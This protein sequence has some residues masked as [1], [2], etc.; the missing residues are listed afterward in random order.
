MK[1]M[2]LSDG[3]LLKKEVSASRPPAEAPM[4]TIGKASDEEGIL[5]FSFEAGFRGVGFL[6]FASGAL[7]FLPAFFTA[8]HPGD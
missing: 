4:P 8:D 3:M 1:A 7:F 2:W 5:T 6:F